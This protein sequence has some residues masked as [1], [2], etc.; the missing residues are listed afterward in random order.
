M[1]PRFLLLTLCALA[2]PGQT[3]PVR[4]LHLSAPRPEEMDLAERFIREALPKEGVNTLIVEF[5]YRYQFTRRPEVAEQDALSR[6]DV[7]RLV[8]A[9][10]QAGVRL[11]PQIN[12]LGHQSWAKTTHALLRAHPEFDETPGRYPDNEGIYCRSYCPRH[13]GVHA[14]VF[15]LID[16]LVEACE[17]DAFH[18][19][20]DEVFLLGED[21][22]PRC[23]GAAKAE[24][25]A[26]EV[27]AI[28]DHLARSNRTLWIWGDRL[29][30]GEVTG[31]GKW[32]ASANGTAPA[33]KMIPNDVVICDW[34]Y[35]AAHPTASYF[36]IA[37]FQVVSSPWRKASVAL[38]QLDLIRM[39]RSNASPAVGARLLGMVQTTWAGFGK[40]AKGYFREDTTDARAMESVNCFRELFR[41]LRNQK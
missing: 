7:K 18:A 3:L 23:R 21:D 32:E 30:D 13:P 1:N 4:G 35:E 2:L 39:A 24:L 40:F 10:R 36:A 29:L 27:N 20:M 14:V 28:R 15:D 19:G 25:F 17:A 33:L 16:E 8:A 11:I 12:L 22:C 38:R 9:A 6:E 26:G 31:I 5:G 34:H 41:E 37:G